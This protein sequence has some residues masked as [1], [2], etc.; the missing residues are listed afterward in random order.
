MQYKSYNYHSFN[1]YTIKTDKFKN[2]HIEIVFRNKIKK[3]EIMNRKFLI[4]L[5]SLSTKKYNS[6]KDLTIYLEELYNTNFYTLISRV[7]GTIFTNFCFDF[8]NPIYTNKN[9]IEEILNLIKEIIYNPN[10]NKDEFS[11][12]DFNIVKNNIIAEIKEAKEDKKSYGYRRLFK[13]MDD[14][15]YLS[16]DMLG[17]IKEIEDITSKDVLK[18]YKNM[19]DNDY[20]DIYVIGN[21]DMDK[22]ATYFDHNFFNRIIKTYSIPLYSECVR[23]KKINIVKEQSDISQAN[24]FIGCNI[25]GLSVEQKDIVAYLYNYLL[26]GGLDTKLGKCLRQENN[27]CYSVNSIYQK[28]DSVIIIYAGIDPSNYEKCIKLIKKA[29]KEMI[30]IITESEL[31]E[32]K[33]N[34]IS[35]LNM[36]NDNPATIINN[37]IFRNIAGLK[38]VEERVKNIKKITV[39]DIKKLAKKVKINTIYMLSGVK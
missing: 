37:Y 11:I 20:C 32:A 26:G 1:V 7:G 30:T 23:R 21:L 8:L 13:H 31:E 33:K 18:T 38:T 14:K 5:M 19:I 6:S 16:Y 24:L 3:E 34:I 12:D 28:Y 35:S 2:C 27:L 36:I 29:L 39:D 9:F 17:D 15:S 25:N 10:I 22:I 4:E